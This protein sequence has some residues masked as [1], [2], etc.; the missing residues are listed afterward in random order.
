M[1]PSQAFGDALVP[2]VDQLLARL[3]ARGFAEQQDGR[4]RLTVAG[5]RAAG[6]RAGD[7]VGDDDLVAT[8]NRLARAVDLEV[9]RVT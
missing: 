5:R 4:I 9:P 2:F 7:V 6:Y 1:A 8:L 3:V